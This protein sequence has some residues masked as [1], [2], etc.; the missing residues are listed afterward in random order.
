MSISMY[1]VTYK[2]FKQRY[3]KTVKRKYIRT[4]RQRYWKK[5]K[6]G[7][8][9]RYWRKIKQPYWKKFKQRFWK[10]RYKA[11]IR[12]KGKRFDF[13]GEPDEIQRAV[14][15][16]LENRY[17]PKKRFVRGSARLFLKNPEKYGYKIRG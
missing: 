16:A 13:Y 5:R 7:I 12:Y 8:R 17:I 2:V 10:K 1:Q 14:E 3:Q 11:V 6:D 15:F 9:Q 4:I